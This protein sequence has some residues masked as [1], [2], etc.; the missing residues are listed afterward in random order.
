MNELAIARTTHTGEIL[1]NWGAVWSSHSMER[2]LSLFTDD[3]IYDD[4]A[5]G[6]INHGKQ[7]L[8]DFAN[9][10]F[11]VFPDFRL[12][13]RSAVYLNNQG[14]VEWTMSGTHAGDLPNLPATNKQFSIRGVSVIEMSL[15][16]VKRCTDYWDLF[17]FQKQV[18]LFKS[19]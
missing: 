7:E 17:T 14:V 15:G 9:A 3:C 6:I 4:V 11:A 16:K 8:E 5:F 13:N 19:L 18:G 10:I 12:E 1:E 2:L